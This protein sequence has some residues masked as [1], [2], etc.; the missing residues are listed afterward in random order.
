MRLTRYLSPAVANTEHSVAVRMR[1]D[2]AKASFPL[3][4]LGS[5]DMACNVDGDSGVN[6][7]ILAS[8]GDE[9]TFNWRTW[10]DGS[11]PGTIDKGHKGPC[12]VYMKKVDDPMA[13]GSGDGWF[14]IWQDGYDET[15]DQW[16]TD[17]L[18][19]NNGMM[20]VNTPS[21]IAQGYYLIRPELLALHAAAGQHQPQYYT[22]CAQVYLK[23]SGSASPPT[24]SI[25]GYNDINDKSDTFNIY[26]KPMALPYPI[27]GP[28]P[29]STGNKKRSLN[30]HRRDTTPANIVG[31][32]PDTC[33]CQNGNWCGVEVPS[34]TNQDSC[35]KTGEQCWAQGKDCYDHASPAGN[36]GCKAWEAKCQAINDA[37]T[38]GNYNQPDNKGKDITPPE[39]FMTASCP[40][41]YTGV[42]QAAGGGSDHTGSGGSSHSGSSSSAP[43]SST[44]SQGSSAAASA[45]DYASSWMVPTGSSTDSAASAATDASSSS[46]MGY[47]YGSPASSSGSDATAGSSSTASSAASNEPTTTSTIF[48]GT[49]TVTSTT[50]GSGVEATSTDECAGEEDTTSSSAASATGGT[51]D[52][53]SAAAAATTTGSSSSDSGEE[54]CTD[55]PSSATS[56]GAEAA[57]VSTTSASMPMITTGP[58]ASDCG[59]VVTITQTVTSYTAAAAPK[60]AKRHV[61]GPRRH[62]HRHLGRSLE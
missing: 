20:S 8:A 60:M 4:D 35:W 38:A 58:S 17:K 10:P 1:K 28:A 19:A 61:E 44:Y 53:A 36:L 43:A 23:S 13:A 3:I 51:T 27:P 50:T 15:S 11:H 46:A 26:D 45:S 48:A 16:C 14:K 29:Y 56:S 24:V 22:G 49:V 12:A 41:P 30:V 55:E 37:C 9:F 59:G 39:M 6:R 5:P 32:K 21:D 62:A 34:S 47:G 57:G 7:T 52:T 2:P 33:I 54:D 18:I 40:A 42:G 25:P 31:L